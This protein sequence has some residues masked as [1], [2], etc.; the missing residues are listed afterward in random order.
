MNLVV[1]DIDGTLIRYHRKKN[2]Q[3][4]VR[5]VQEVFGI[6]IEDGWSDYT[7][8]TDSGILSEI[9]EK[10]KGRS[11]RI[12]DVRD[13][14]KSMGSWLVQEY[15]NE[16]FESTPGAR[17]CLGKLSAD[18]NWVGAIATGNW[19]FSGKFKL[20]SAGLH[21]PD[22]PLASADD[23]LSRETILK[24][25]FCKAQEAYGAEAF[26]RVVYVG[27]WI[28]DVKAA[29]ALGWEFIGI[30]SGEVEQTL[31]ES[32]AEQVLPDFLGFPL[33]LNKKI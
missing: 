6:A 11:C 25:A 15:G 16:P 4:Y 23:G 2:D 27:D 24:T 17:E 30:G 32:G 18:S 5:A 26:E 13:F 31:R 20:R 9:I 10:H 22:I 1:F 14:Q 7:H 33:L 28:W 29:Q 19:Q 21:L 12:E 8:S 3:A